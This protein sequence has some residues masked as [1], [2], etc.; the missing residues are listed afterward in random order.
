MKNHRFWHG[1]YC[2]YLRRVDFF[3]SKTLWISV[4]ISMKIINFDEVFDAL[5][6]GVSTGRRPAAHHRDV[7]PLK[8]ASAAVVEW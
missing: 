8:P 4:G 3:V 6:F 5:T 2:S 7:D 1:F